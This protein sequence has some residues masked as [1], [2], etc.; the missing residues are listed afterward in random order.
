VTST[1]VNQE[2]AITTLMQSMIELK[3]Q[4]SLLKRE[5]E[6]IHSSISKIPKDTVLK[7]RADD[8]TLGLPD[9]SP[10]NPCSNYPTDRD[11]SMSQVKAATETLNF[12]KEAD[13]DH[14]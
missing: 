5:V 9:E 14:D 4:R 6:S 11:F 1:K 13:L 7:F 8:L 10:N 12:K 2:H 3:H